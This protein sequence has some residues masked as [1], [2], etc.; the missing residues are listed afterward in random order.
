M[1]LDPIL[2]RLDTL[3]H[4]VETTVWG[5]ADGPGYPQWP[6]YLVVASAV[7][8][9][10]QSALEP[11]LG[12]FRAGVVAGL[13]A[14]GTL[15]LLGFTRVWAEGWARRWEARGLR[16]TGRL[17]RLPGMAFFNMAVAFLPLA[18]MAPW[19][20]WAHLPKSV[21][22]ASL[23]FGALC[24]QV[25][26][27]HANRGF[28]GL[29]QE[30]RT[31]ALRSRL[32]PHFIFNALNTLK[33]Q[34][35][36]DPAGAEAMA[37]RLARLF[38]QVLEASDEPTIPLRQEL[39]FVEAYLGIEQARL[40]ERLRVVV[41]V[42]EELESVPIPPLSLQ[43]LVENAIKHGVAPREQ[44]GTVR[45]GAE[46]IAGGLLLWVEDPGTGVSPAKGTGTALQTLRQ[47]LA[48]PEDLDMGTV[49]GRH[50][51]SFRWRVA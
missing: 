35:A 23:A 28:V 25:A 16:A 12:A 22:L 43:V 26:G 13:Y 32:A 44:G 31:D 20:L 24:M 27:E 40:G 29:L 6:V 46:R 42:P 39:A 1:N 30:A 41:E 8:A 15:A 47:R 18:A 5:G 14:A 45:I 48:R 49:G 21:A 19:I 2:S 33:A 50:R 9:S 34:I 4:R 37:D 36:A 38:R 3:I 7:Y 10:L 51:V 17:R 11:V